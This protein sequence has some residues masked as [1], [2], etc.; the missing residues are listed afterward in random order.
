MMSLQSDASGKKRGED[1][2]Y[3]YEEWGGDIMTDS[4]D[5]RR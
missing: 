4:T 5:I 2:N 3:Q 1:T